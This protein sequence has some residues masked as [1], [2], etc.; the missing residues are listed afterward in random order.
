MFALTHL[1][2]DSNFHHCEL[3]NKTIHPTINIRGLPLFIAAE[4]KYIRKYAVVYF[5]GLN[6]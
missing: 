3:M 5:G 4:N 6:M 2:F 1:L